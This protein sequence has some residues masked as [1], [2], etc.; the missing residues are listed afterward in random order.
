MI[1]E[2]NI[3]HKTHLFD[4]FSTPKIVYSNQVKEDLVESLHAHMRFEDILT[5]FFYFLVT[6]V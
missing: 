6:L 1:I 3:Y 4:T 5:F 2:L